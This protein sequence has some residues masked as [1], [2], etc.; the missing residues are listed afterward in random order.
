[1]YTYVNGTRIYFDIDGEGLTPDGAVIRKKPTVVMVHGGPGADHTVSKPYFSQLTDIAQV[2]FY[3]HRGNGRSSGDDPNQWNLAQWGDD[4]H[5]L[6]DALGIERPI[7]IG[8]SF[9]GFVSLAYATRHPDHAAGLVLISTAAKV[10]FQE[11]Y[12]A[13]ERLGGA[14]IAK[15]AQEYWEN[16][17]EDGRALYRDRCVPLYQR[18]ESASLEWLSRVLWRNETAL[19]FNGPYAEH[20]RMDFRNDLNRIAC[21]VLLMVGE[22]DPITPPVFSDVIADH[23]PESQL[24]YH[25][26]AD[27][28]HG[29]VADRPEEARRAIRTFIERIADDN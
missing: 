25:R 23:L 27:C 28:G 26:F 20:G 1:M 3:D 5:G 22:E 14:E 19:H 9:G 24:T 7:V 16:P 18:V 15:I 17:T 13:F 21:P 4:L 8:T 11:V 6:C 10:E 29:V 12:Q 2:V